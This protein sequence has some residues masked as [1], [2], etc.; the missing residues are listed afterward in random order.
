[1]LRLKCLGGQIINPK[2]SSSFFL[3]D[4]FHQFGAPMPLEVTTPSH[5]DRLRLTIIVTALKRDCGPIGSMDLTSG[6]SYKEPLPIISLHRWPC[7]WVTGVITPMSGVV[8]LLYLW[9][10]PVGA[11]LVQIP[12]CQTSLFWKNLKISLAWNLSN[13]NIEHME[14]KFWVAGQLLLCLSISTI[15]SGNCIN[16]NVNYSYIY[17]H[18]C[19]ISYGS[20]LIEY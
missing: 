17:P 4:N 19:N 20:K 8:T 9:L 6:F 12:S 3:G 10:V 11:H 14:G 2:C 15:S 7:K 13:K 5:L 1:M 18:V 16:V